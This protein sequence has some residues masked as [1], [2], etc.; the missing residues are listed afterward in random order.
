MMTML[1]MTMLVMTMLMMT[2]LMMT[3]LVVTM[4]MMT[5]LVMVKV[6]EELYKL[7]C[8]EESLPT[9]QRHRSYISVSVY[10]L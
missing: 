4:L 2:M 5:M 7:T 8:R 3:M 1:M 10:G 9:K 6:H